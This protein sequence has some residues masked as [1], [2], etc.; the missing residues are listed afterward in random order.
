MKDVLK[1]DAKS[2]RPRTSVLFTFNGNKAAD[3]GDEHVKDEMSPR[4]KSQLSL[5]RD[6]VRCD[7]VGERWLKRIMR[8]LRVESILP[9][10]CCGASLSG[11]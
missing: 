8:S 4:W 7:K 11:R 5:N 1:G 10:A 9:Q 2:L 3:D 6:S